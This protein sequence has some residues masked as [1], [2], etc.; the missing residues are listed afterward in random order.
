MDPVTAADSR[1]TRHSDLE[2][3][4]ALEQ[5]SSGSL[6][7]VGPA[8]EGMRS[9]LEEQVDGG[10]VGLAA[11]GLRSELR[12]VGDDG[13]AFADAVETAVLDDLMATVSTVLRDNDQEGWRHP[14]TGCVVARNTDLESGRNR[15]WPRREFDWE[16]G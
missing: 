3:L 14:R 7:R 10:S 5:V 1:T 16:R 2:G 9:E 15:G 6:K 8:A 13:S 4:A 12:E 11:R